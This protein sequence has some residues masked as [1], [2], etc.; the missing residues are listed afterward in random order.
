MSVGDYILIP[1]GIIGIIISV[2]C[3]ISY[4]KEHNKSNKS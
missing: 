3:V 2:W 1:L 4:E